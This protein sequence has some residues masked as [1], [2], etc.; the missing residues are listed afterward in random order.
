MGKLRVPSHTCRSGYLL[1]AA[2]ADFAK[3][4]LVCGCRDSSILVYLLPDTPGVAV[5]H[6][7]PAEVIPIDYTVHLTKT[8]DQQAVTSITIHG[9]ENTEDVMSFY[10]T[11]RDG[12]YS[13]YIVRL[14]NK[15]RT[16]VLVERAYRAK[17][18]K[19]W[20]EGVIYLSLSYSQ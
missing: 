14:P 18:T 20:L 8:H 10:S 12:I 7:D 19:G 17:V 15:H 13:Q 16:S 4:T 11:G 6:M 3:R 9:N 1:I 5:N 2:D